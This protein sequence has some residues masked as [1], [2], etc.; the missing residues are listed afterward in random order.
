MPSNNDQLGPLLLSVALHA[1]L[2]AGLWATTL[3]CETWNA[4]VVR[5]Q[6]PQLLTM[7][8]S[9][10]LDLEGP[11]IEAM[12][13]DYTPPTTTRAQVARPRPQP[14]R[15]Q[16]PVPEPPPPAPLLPPNPPPATDVVEQERIDRDGQLPALEAQREQEERR[17][18]EQIE[19]EMQQRLTA[20]ERD[21]QQ[22]LD[23]IRRQR[24]QAQQRRELEEQRL[25]QLV[26][27]QRADVADRQRQNEAERMQ[28]LLERENAQR[29]GTG[30]TQNDLR[31]RYFFAITQQ[32]QQNW[33]RPDST[34]P[35]IRCSIRI[36]Q[37]PGGDVIDVSFVGQCNTDELTRRSIEAA[38]R[39][40]PLPY[41]G[42][43]SV[44][45]RNITFDF[46]WDG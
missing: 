24:E 20:M 9:K 28:D 17:K 42:Y 46:S 15:P 37:I 45:T 12:L 38:V 39:R 41:A 32:V 10:P 8:C 22:Q 36:A 11:V 40:A 29:A 1:L 13:V 2:L 34:R 31:S 27:Q 25:A 43:E 21:R 33:L 16:P 7:T 44:F 23:D 30:G 19:L 5:L 14:P 3:G 35:P 26:D 4:A 6:L 18:R